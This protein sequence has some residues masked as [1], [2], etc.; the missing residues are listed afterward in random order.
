[1]STPKKPIDLK[2]VA[3]QQRLL[4]WLILF[5]ILAN[6]FM[7]ATASRS[8][9]LMIIT[10]LG[11]LLFQLLALIQVYRLTISMR[12]NIAWPIVMTLFFWV[13]L[14]SL[15]ILLV[16]NGKANTMLKQTGVKIGLMGV[17]KSEYP[18]LMPGHCRFCGYNREGLDP[19]AACPEC[20]NT[21]HPPQ[22]RVGRPA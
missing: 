8:P 5:I 10:M 19:D 11:A 14:L 17:S 3:T 2:S 12:A 20:G 6:I 21:S 16:I 4:L 15:I 18:K 1:M 22:A 7:L 13:P 9:Q